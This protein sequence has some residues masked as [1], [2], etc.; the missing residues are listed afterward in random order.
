MYTTASEKS[1]FCAVIVDSFILKDP[2][3]SAA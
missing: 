1:S 2:S 3:L